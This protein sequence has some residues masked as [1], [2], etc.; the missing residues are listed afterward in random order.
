MRL[1]YVDCFSGISGDMALGALLH[2]GADFDAVA[3]ALRPLPVNEFSLEAETVEVRGTAATRVHVHAGPQE[4]IRT[5]AS[6]R[7]L[8]EDLD[9]EEEPR[10][11][12]QRIYRHLASA[13]AAVGGKDVELATFHEFG[14]LDCLVEVV[15]CALALDMLGIDRIFASPVPTGMGMVRTEHGLTP[16]PSPVVS[17]LLRGVPTYSRSVPAELVSPV[18]AAI[19]AALSEGYG[20]QPTMRS[21]RV[22]YGAGPARGDLPALLRITVGQEHRAGATAAG[23][24]PFGGP[25]QDLVIEATLAD[26]ETE[27][28]ER[29][30]DRLLSAGARDTWVTPVMGQRGQARMTLTALTAAAQADAVADTLRA[31]AGVGEVRLVPVRVL[32][33]GSP[34]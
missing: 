25:V 14:P 7:R 17:E 13:V 1:A 21:D 6:I 24:G 27:R 34:R 20:D 31:E 5:Y 22:G 23:V 3:A 26:M 19:L 32:E 11:T 9:L 18:G 28:C 33:P 30:M 4:V 2:A 12:A 29:L 8:L 15:G 16:V 10:R